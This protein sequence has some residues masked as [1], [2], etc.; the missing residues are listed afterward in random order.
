[1]GNS[2]LASARTELGDKHQEGRTPALL[3]GEILDFVK[4]S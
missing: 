3:S 4:I 1:V 2:Q